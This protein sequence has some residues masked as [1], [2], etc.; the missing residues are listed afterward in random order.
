MS[1]HWIT[2][3]PAISSLVSAK[4]PSV[5]MGLPRASKRTRL[6]AELGC[7]PA[8]SSMTPAAIISLLKA[9]ISANILAASAGKRPASDSS[10]AFTIIR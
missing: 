10:V 5:T 4:G 9:P 3:K 7:R 2:Q 1:L 8:P 6:P